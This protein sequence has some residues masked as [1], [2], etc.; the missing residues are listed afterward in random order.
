[1]LPIEIIGEDPAN[2]V[3]RALIL[4]ERTGLRGFEYS[5]PWELSGGM[6]QRVALCRALIHRPQLLLLDEPFSSLDA[7]TR[8]EMWVLL[9]SVFL[10]ENYTTLLVTHDI[11]EAVLLSDRVVVMSGKPGRVKT[12]VEIPFKRPRNI[13][14]QYSKEFNEYVAKIK[15]MLSE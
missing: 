5:Y 1:L 11:R 14:L 7:I 2:Y 12:E 8:E 4:M 13:S 9:E 10:Y 6:Q 15:S 3:E